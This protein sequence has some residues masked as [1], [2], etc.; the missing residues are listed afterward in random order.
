MLTG[1]LVVESSSGIDSS[2]QSIF[3]ASIFDQ[4][5]RSIFATRSR[6][7]L[8]LPCSILR[9]ISINLVNRSANPLGSSCAPVDCL[10][11][12][13]RTVLPD[14]FFRTVPVDRA[15]FFFNSS[16]LTSSFR[17]RFRL[18]HR[19]NPSVS[20]AIDTGLLL[21]RSHFDRSCSVCRIICIRCWLRAT[22][23]NTT[24]SKSNTDYATVSTVDTAWYPAT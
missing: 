10:L 7:R 19:R 20:G 21:L 13:P 18:S 4:R 24:Q 23:R 17:S 11:L 1:V 8:D 3:R 14:R 9:S 15:P 16:L 22:P 5:S 2:L 6:P 12:D